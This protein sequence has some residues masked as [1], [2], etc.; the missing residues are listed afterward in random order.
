MDHTSAPTNAKRVCLR[1]DCLRPSRARGL[2]V[3]H[4]QA[5]LWAE[6]RLAQSQKFRKTRLTPDERFDRY[7]AAG[8]RSQCWEWTAGRDA[9]GYGRFMLHGSAVPASRYALERS[10]GTASA[11]MYACHR[12][13]NPPCVNP[14]HLYWGTRQDNADDAVSRGRIPVGEQKAQAVLTEAQVIEIRELHASGQLQR[15][16]AESFGISA[17]TVRAIALGRKWKHVGGPI[18]TKRKKK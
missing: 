18:S 14:S 1:E 17:Q 12:C 4:Y 13:D 6:R 3:N 16:I 8:A 10:T 15:V 7:F 9:S 2:C 11:G 5:F